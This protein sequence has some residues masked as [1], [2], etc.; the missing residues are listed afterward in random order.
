MLGMFTPEFC[1]FC[2]PHG[3]DKNGMNRRDDARDLPDCCC[4]VSLQY[5]SGNTAAG[6]V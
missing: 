3:K 1:L 2:S 5:G 4:C 6:H